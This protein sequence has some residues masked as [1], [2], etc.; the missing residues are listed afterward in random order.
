MQESLLADRNPDAHARDLDVHYRV[1]YPDSLQIQIEGQPQF[2]GLRNL[3]L[4]GKF[5]LSEKV[6]INADDRTTKE[7]AREISTQLNLRE[8]SISVRV[9]DYRSQVIF[10]VGEIG[11]RSRVVTY[12]G[13]ET[14]LDLMQRIGGVE[15][16][17]TVADVRIVRSHVAEGRMPEVF[18][19]DLPSILSKKDLQSNVRLQAGDR[20]YLGQSRSSEVACCLPAWLKKIFGSKKPFVYDPFQPN[21]GSTANPS[22]ATTPTSGITSIPSVAP[23]PKMPGMHGNDSRPVLSNSDL[24]FDSPSR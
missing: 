17:E 15:K 6:S 12:I 23:F 1:R 13:P 11:D 9:Q 10:L 8:E 5:K 14:V 24:V 19:V 16:G 4:D 22:S 20:I 7:I 18:P 2:S 3:E 21:P